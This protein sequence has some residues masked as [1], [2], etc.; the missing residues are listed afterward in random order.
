MKL[1]KEIKGSM[2]YLRLI[3]LRKVVQT[4]KKT[5]PNKEIVQVMAKRR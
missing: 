2:Q 1:K 4:T 3:S 5:L